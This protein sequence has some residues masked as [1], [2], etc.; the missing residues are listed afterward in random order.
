MQQNKQQQGL[1]EMA[2]KQ[3]KLKKLIAALQA[4]AMTTLVCIS[5]PAY[6][7]DTELYKAP[8]SSETTIMF[9][10]DVSGSMNDDNRL[11]NLKSG[12][13]KLLQGDTNLEPLPDKLVVG[14]SEFSGGGN[15]SSGTGR[16]KIE[17]RPL[18][19]ETALNGYRAIYQTVQTFTQS[20]TRINTESTS[21]TE[22]N[23]TRTQKGI[24]VCDD[25]SNRRQECDDWD[26]PYPTSENLDGWSV[27]TSPTDSWS[28]T[29]SGAWSL[30]GAE[31]PTS[32]LSPKECIEWNINEDSS[33]SSGTTVNCKTWVVTQKKN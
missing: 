24:R 19:E 21:R 14:L 31:T 16:I 20:A 27:S 18:G 30:R 28:S 25:W 3:F 4:G 6:A 22:N 26:S 15:T 29:N 33:I 8:R 11:S 2:M 9:M 12:M 10:M 7:S 5:L 32:D 17:A 23:K 1:E 13:I